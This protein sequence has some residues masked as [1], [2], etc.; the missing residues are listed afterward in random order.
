MI[1]KEEFWRVMETY[2]ARILP[3]QVVFYVAAI[4]VVAWLFLRP[5]RMQSLFA[6]LYLAVAFAWTGVL[7][8]FTL[9]SDLAGDSCGNVVF[10]SIF[11]LVSAL[12][13]VDMVR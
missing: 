2:G 3:A 9:A 11:I 6:K 8:Y 1:P 12:F 4:L 13:L 10:G 5:G 7:F